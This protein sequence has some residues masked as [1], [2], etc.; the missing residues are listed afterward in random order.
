MISD[1]LVALIILGASE[2]AGAEHFF[3]G[4]YPMS[5]VLVAAYAWGFLGAAYGSL[6]LVGEQV[7]VNVMGERGEIP[8]AGSVTFLVFGVVVG[9]GF[10]AL[11]DRER[12]AGDGGGTS[13]RAGE[14]G[15]RATPQGA[16]RGASRVGQPATRLRSANARCPQEGCHRRTAGPVPGASPG[17]ITASHHRRVPVAV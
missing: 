10:D 16:L 3:H 17:K 2:I 9:W 4:G 14:P 15:D 5:W 11:R 8:A 13:G 7:V 12:A 1:L 6:F